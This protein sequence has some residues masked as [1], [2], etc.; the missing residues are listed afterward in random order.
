MINQHKIAKTLIKVVKKSRD[1]CYA[2]YSK[3]QVSAGVYC[4]NG[5]IYTG[6]NIENSSYSLTMCAER[7]AIYRAYLEGE[8]KFLLMLLWSPQVDFI[9][10]CGACL[11]VLSELAPDIVIATMNS[12]EEFRFY[13]LSALIK[14][15][16][17]M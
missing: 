6:V 2:P 16:F 5:K 10:P 8:K 9:T 17:R 15:P 13:P 12:S 3:I 11:Q 1:R 4:G 14:K 7:T